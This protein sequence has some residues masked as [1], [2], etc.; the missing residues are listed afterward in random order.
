MTP[1]K[2]EQKMPKLNHE[3]IDKVCKVIANNP[4]KFDMDRWEHA[5]WDGGKLVTCK[6]PSCIAGWA[7]FFSGIEMPD[8]ESAHTWRYAG[9]R[10]LGIT[11]NEAVE[12][13]HIMYWPKELRLRYND[14]DKTAAIDMLNLIIQK[15]NDIG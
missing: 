7:I 9:A 8:D 12:L 2:K 4:N 14:G 1:I 10:A 5:I 6:T 3:I 13:F 15:H 11:L